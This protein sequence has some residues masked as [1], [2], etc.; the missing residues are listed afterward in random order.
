MV[1]EKLFENAIW[2]SV[3]ILIRDKVHASAESLTWNAVY[4]LDWRFVDSQVLDP[5]YHLIDNSI[6]RHVSES[7]AYS[8]YKLNEK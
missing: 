3:W 4:T 7:A 5:V 6:V 8:I 2:W 1:T